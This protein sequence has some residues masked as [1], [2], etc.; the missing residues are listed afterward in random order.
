MIGTL[1]KTSL[2]ATVFLSA[3]AMSGA[4]LAKKVED[5]RTVAAFEKVAANGSSDVI[6]K[7]GPKRSVVVHAEADEAGEIKTEVKNGEL[8]VWRKSSKRISFGNHGAYVVITMPKLTKLATRGSGDASVTGMKSDKFTLIQQGSGD[9][10]LD[11]SCKS[12]DLTSQGSGDFESDK[13]KCDTVDIELRGSGDMTIEAFT[14]KDVSLDAVGSGDVSFRGTCT[15]FDIH[16]MA[17]GDVDAHKF[18]CKTVSVKSQGSG[19]MRVFATDD[20]TT[21][22]IQGSGDVEVY[23]GAKPGVVKTHGSGSVRFHD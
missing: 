7:V 14:S 10:E 16:H 23:G 13:F 2:A 8:T 11:G 15:S 20:A 21:I 3:S 4:A 1:L 6:I 18:K 12:A 5:K 17:S 9:V 19:D 22:K